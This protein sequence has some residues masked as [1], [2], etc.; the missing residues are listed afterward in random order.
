MSY[1]NVRILLLVPFRLLDEINIRD[2]PCPFSSNV[3]ASM[4]RRPIGY[5]SRAGGVHEADLHQLPKTGGDQGEDTCGLVLHAH[6]R[7]RRRSKS[8]S[9]RPR[10][11]TIQVQADDYQIWL[12]WGFFSPP[13]RFTSMRTTARP[14]WTALSKAASA[15]TAAKTCKT[16]PSE[17]STS[18]TMTAACTSATWCASSSSTSSSPRSPWPRTSGCSWRRKVRST[19][20]HSG[21]HCMLAAGVTWFFRW[22]ESLRLIL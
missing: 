10:L 22:G 20:V 18:R 19:A 17:S 4:C 5:R 7:K 13:P 21:L 16:S 1:D 3:P 11:L 12:C 15:G 9:R 6:Q 8:D 14:T 2:F